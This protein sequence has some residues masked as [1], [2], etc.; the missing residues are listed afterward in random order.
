LEFVF[1]FSN[2]EE[3]LGKQRRRYPVLEAAKKSISVRGKILSVTG[4]RKNYSDMLSRLQ[5]SYQLGRREWNNRNLDGALANWTRAMELFPDPNARV[6]TY[7]GIPAAVLHQLALISS[8]IGL[9]YLMQ[10]GGTTRALWYFQHAYWYMH[11]DAVVM[12]RLILG[13]HRMGFVRAATELYCHN[14]LDQKLRP[15]ETEHLKKL[16]F[17]DPSH[18]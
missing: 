11:E 2:A 1:H 9:Y 18:R 4:G 16:L 8:C 5:F 6:L 3:L 10:E 13:L 15:V 17:P 12:L 14:N 7:Q